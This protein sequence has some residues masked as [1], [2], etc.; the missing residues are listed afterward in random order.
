MPY[1]IDDMDW[2]PSHYHPADEPLMTPDF[3]AWHHCG[4]ECGNKIGDFQDD[5]GA[6]YVHTPNRGYAGI[7]KS[8]WDKGGYTTAER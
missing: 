1:L 2:S 7:C 5:C 4:M 6:F 8:C 3:I